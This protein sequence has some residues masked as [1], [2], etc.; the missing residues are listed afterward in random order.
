MAIKGFFTREFYISGYKAVLA[1]TNADYGIEV[2]YYETAKSGKPCAIYF[3]GKAQ[4]PVAHN[5]YS[6]VEIR[7]QIALKFIS[8]E[9]KMRD[10]KK[11]AK[12]EKLQY[13]H[14]LK[15]GD[16]LHSSWGYEQ[17]NNDFYQVIAVK[18]KSVVLREIAQKKEYEHWASGRTQPVKDHFI[19]EPFIKR[20]TTGNCVKI[21]SYAHASPCDASMTTYFSEYA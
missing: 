12:A 10:E 3:T 5:S 7:E 19:G 17:T 21:E 18:G 2:Y 4:K 6:S 9:I 14:T 11:Q 15:A 16:I 20:V 8:A 13:Q 1:H